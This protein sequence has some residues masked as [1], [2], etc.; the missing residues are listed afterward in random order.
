MFQSA[1]N[2]AT[3]Q[4]IVERVQFDKNAERSVRAMLKGC[5]ESCPVEVLMQ[6]GQSLLDA[7]RSEMRAQAEA[8]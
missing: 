7:R 8:N 5:A 2:V 4:Q 6:L 3:F 1:D